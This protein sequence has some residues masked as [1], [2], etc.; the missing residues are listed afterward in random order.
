MSLM[1]CGNC[2]KTTYVKKTGCTVHVT[3]DEGNVS[4]HWLQDADLF[5]CRL[6]EME[7]LTGFA[8]E[9]WFRG[10]LVEIEQKLQQMCLHDA[11][12]MVRELRLH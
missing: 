8:K 1:T 4:Q 11:N 3:L 12:F 9:P 10:T 5:G 2:G 6:C 7:V